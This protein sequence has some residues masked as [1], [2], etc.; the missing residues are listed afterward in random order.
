MAIPSLG[1]T[2]WV[3]A[4]AFASLAGALPLGAAAQDAAELELGKKLFSS[5]VP[6]CA[7]CHTLKDA[8]ASGSIGPDLDELRPDAARVGAAMRNGIGSMPSFRSNLTEAQLAAVARYVAEA[9]GG[10]R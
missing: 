8:G 9:S 10:A 7:L 1:R 4:I 5:A 2:R 6:A 3:I